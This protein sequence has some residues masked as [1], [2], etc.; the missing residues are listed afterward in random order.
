MLKGKAAGSGSS[1]EDL[2]E[3]V[4][5]GLIAW[6]DGE[7]TIQYEA[8]YWG[9]WRSKIN[10]SDYIS[11][12]AQTFGDVTTNK[13]IK[14]K[15]CIVNNKTFGYR[16]RQDFYK[17]GYTIEAVGRIASVTNSTG[18]T[19][20]W[21]ITMNE[22]GT[23]GIGVTDNPSH[24]SITFVNSDNTSDK[25]VTNCYNKIFG[26]SLFLEKV[27]A[28]GAGTTP[29]YCKA[30]INGSEWFNVVEAKATTGSSREGHGILCYYADTSGAS[31]MAEGELYCLRIYNRKLT[32][33]ELLHNHKIDKARFDTF[34]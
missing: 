2:G 15:K 9:V 24:G 13:M 12:A 25:R 29:D 33:E 19:G 26:A 20:G 28:R 3:Y 21:L 18:N 14:T 6:F 4:Q 1:E 30:S 32:N 10:S 16:L 7:D 17:Q 11:V 22:T 23:W 31:Y 27:S 8:G 5:D 34:E